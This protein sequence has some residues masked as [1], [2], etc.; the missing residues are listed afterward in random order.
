MSR[1]CHQMGCCKLPTFNKVRKTSGKFCAEHKKDGMVNIMY[2]NY[3]NQV[4]HI[5]KLLPQ[6]LKWEILVE[7][8]GGFTVRNNRLRRLLSG[9]IH[10][11]I[12]EH[13]YELNH[14]SWRRLW[15]K[16]FVRFPFYD[17]DHM[18]IMISNRRRVKN[19]RSDGT[20]WFD[21][22]Y[23]SDHDF[24]HELLDI[25]AVAEFSRRG[26]CVVLF[27]SKHTGNLSY[28]YHSFYNTGLEGK[29]YIIDINDSVI[30]PPFEKHYYPSYPYTN[31]KLG[32]PVLKM[33]LHNPIAEVPE[34]LSDNGIKAW[35]EGRYF[36]R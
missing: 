11:K 33:K 30:L 15:L 1:T 14:L 6:E 2:K 9:T 24:D 16:P 34:G 7:F 35:M 8:V 20:I 19:F 28:G 10:E 36:I 12:V 18:W 31:K 17:Y 21:H 23:D 29:W 13:N 22:H 3:N 26:N 32:R 27:K 25:V 4:D 5:F